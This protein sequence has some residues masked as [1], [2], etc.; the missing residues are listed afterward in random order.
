MSTFCASNCEGLHF[1]FRFQHFS[2]HHHYSGLAAAGHFLAVFTVT[3]MAGDHLVAIELIAK[4][5]A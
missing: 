3:M 4:V 5:A 2:G 1:P